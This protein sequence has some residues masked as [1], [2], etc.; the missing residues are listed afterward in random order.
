MKQMKRRKFSAE[1]K[2]NAVRLSEIGDKGVSQ[3]EHELG[4]SRGQLSHWRRLYLEQG[5][6]AFEPAPRSEME[7]EVQRLRRE[8]ARLKEEQA[9][10]KKVLTMFSQ[11]A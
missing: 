4:L 1:F 8:N 3:L 7:R 9:I 11:D 2:R 6:A 10:L 5:V